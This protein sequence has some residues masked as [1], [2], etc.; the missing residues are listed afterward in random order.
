[1]AGTDRPNLIGDPCLDP[2]RPRGE[3]ITQYANPA[4]FQVPPNFT[5]GNAPRLLGCRGEG[6]T[7]SDLSIIKFFPIKET[8]RAEFRGEFINA[9]NRPQLGMPNMTFNSGAFGVITSQ[10]NT[11][12]VIQF[13]IRLN[14]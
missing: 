14:F 5:F 11:P 3:K 12:R 2:G 8:F 13:S 6:I 1:M 4:A 7:N 10:Q 9:F